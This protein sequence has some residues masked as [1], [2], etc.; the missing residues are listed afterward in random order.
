MIFTILI[1]RSFCQGGE[2]SALIPFAYRISQD[3]GPFL[4]ITSDDTLS[5]VLETLSVV[6]EVDQGKWLTGELAQSL[7]SAVLEVW[8]KN[9]KGREMVMGFD[10]K[11]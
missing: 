11:F 9:N 7:I 4:L 5:L 6:L 2:D 1:W 10:N 8:S 3:L